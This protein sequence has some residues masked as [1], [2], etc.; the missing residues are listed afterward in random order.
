MQTQEYVTVARILRAHGVHGEIKVEPLTH[1]L[2][3][4]KTLN[5]VLV[6]CSNGKRLEKEV[7]SGK[8]SGD[9]W[10]LKFADIHQPEDAQ[11]LHNAFLLIPLAERLPAPSGLYYPSD[12]KGLIVLDDN[13][14]Q[15]GKV[16]DMLVFPSV[17]SLEISV[18][19]KTIM[20]PMIDACV[21]EIDLTAHTVKIHF[22]FIADLL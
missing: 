17:N 4:Y 22:D 6:E 1:D 13:G 15:R 21:G 2:H 10:Y 5:K 14:N 9:L 18:S 3:R 7:V 8:L 12:L 11:E 19:G 20:A 16:L